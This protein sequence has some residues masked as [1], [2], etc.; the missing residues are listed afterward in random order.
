MKSSR[1]SSA[2]SYRPPFKPGPRPAPRQALVAEGNGA[3][4]DED[5]VQPEEEELIPA[6]GGGQSLEE[7]L[8]AEAEILATELQELENDEDIDPGLIDELEAGVAAAESLVTM[9]EARSRIAEV[10]KDRGFGKIGGGKGKQ[11]TSKPKAAAKKTGTMCW[12]CGEYGHWQ[13]DSQCQRPGAGLFKPKGKGTN[14]TVQKHVRV[15]ES[16]NTEHLVQAVEAVDDAA[17]VHEVLATNCDESTLSSALDFGHSVQMTQQ[18]SLSNDKKLVGALD[19]ACNRTVSGE[20]WMKSYSSKVRETAP[21]SVKSMIAAV[22]ESEVFRFGNGGTKTSY[23]RYRIPIVVGNTL[24]LVWVSIVAVPSLGLLLG[25]DFMDA[26]GAVI[27]FSRKMLRA[28]YLD[29]TLVRLK[30]LT[31]GHFA[32]Q[33]APSRWPQPGALKWRLS[34]LAGVGELQVTSKEWFKRK[35]EVLDVQN[36]KPEHEHLVTE[37][38]VQAADVGHSGLVAS[39]ELELASQ[40]LAHGAQ[41]MTSCS[42]SSNRTSPASSISARTTS[43]KDNGRRHQI[44][45]RSA[46]P[47]QSASGA[48]ASSKSL[49]RAR[50]SLV[51]LAAAI[52][53]VCAVPLSKC[54]DGRA[55]AIAGRPNGSG[56]V[57]ISSACDE[58]LAAQGI[59]CE[60]S[61]RV[62]MASR[63]S[64]TSSSLLGG[65]L[66]DW[67]AGSSSSTRNGC[68]PSKSSH[69]RSQSRGRQVEGRWKET[70]GPSPIGGSSRRLANSQSRPPPLGSSP[71]RSAGQEGYRQ[72]DQRALPSS[73]QGHDSSKRR[74]PREVFELYGGKQERKSP[75]EGSS[76]ESR[77]R[78]STED[79]ASNGDGTRTFSSRYFR[80]DGTARDQVSRN[81]DSSDAARDGHDQ[82]DGVFVRLQH[83]QHSE[84]IHRGG[85]NAAE[86]RLLRRT[87][88]R[89][90][91]ESVW[92]PSAECKRSGDGGIGLKSSADESLENNPY[93]IHQNVKPGVGQLVA[94]AWAQHERDRK[95]VS[96]S[97]H[98]ANET[99]LEDWQK[100]M[101]ACLNE[102]F[103]ATIK[104]ATG[105]F[106]Q[107]ILLHHNV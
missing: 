75:E 57:S 59:Y 92:L 53:A 103:V 98:D 78:P 79:R 94:Q 24:L 73:P 3:V 105:P 54:Q 17:P 81:V 38:G 102:T 70:R 6:D 47:L 91:R 2:S 96:T 90:L 61:P 18:G 8:Q 30:Q 71:S 37:Q 28:D 67:N 44:Q 49:A 100:Q 48:N 27:S 34:G 13:G 106:M 68:L 51:D 29:G 46:L 66:A 39:G 82:S 74:C 62:D 5:E 26:I 97:R 63:P 36:S 58:G 99:M 60:E 40:S 101:D 11:T 33:L 87:T 12:D 1:F 56:K 20:L 77:E 65:R 52:L 50:P 80:T 69:C 31:A 41:A 107:E 84:G 76:T 86:R 23:V 21:E 45:G 22:A 104:Q 16:N 7:V 85:T 55:V 88:S 83:G 43:S 72:R 89:S 95:M 64:W 15:S 25:R 35:V 4:E 93:K 32:L 14:T 10:K 9:R 42:N 19:S